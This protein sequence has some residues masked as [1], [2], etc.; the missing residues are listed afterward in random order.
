MNKKQDGT[1]YVQ[2]GTKNNFDGYCDIIKN[3]PDSCANCGKEHPVGTIQHITVLGVKREPVCNIDCAIGLSEKWEH[4]YAHLITD[5]R[6]RR[7]ELEEEKE[8]QQNGKAKQ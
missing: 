7:T 4:M 8:E 6:K 5:L 2:Q 3:M 1:T